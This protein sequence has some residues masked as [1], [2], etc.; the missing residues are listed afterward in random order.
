[1]ASHLPRELYVAFTSSVKAVTGRDRRMTGAG[2]RKPSCRYR[3][4]EAQ[5]LVVLEQYKDHCG[6]DWIML[7]NP[8]YGSFESAPFNHDFKKSEAERRKAKRDAL[9]FWPGP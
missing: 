8:T 7:P 6:R 3:G 9:E 2:R 4:N 1:M 5:R